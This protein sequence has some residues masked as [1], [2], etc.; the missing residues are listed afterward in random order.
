MK[1]AFVIQIIKIGED[2][3]RVLLK[4]YQERQMPDGQ[5]LFE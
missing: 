4:K 2:Y 3:V 1:R 5:A